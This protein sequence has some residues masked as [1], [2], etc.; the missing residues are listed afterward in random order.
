M[1][2]PVGL[3]RVGLALVAPAASA[4]RREAGVGDEAFGDVA[5]PGDEDGVGEG[6]DLDVGAQF[7][8]GQALDQGVAPLGRDIQHHAVL[9]APDEEVEQQTSR[10]RQKRAEAKLSGRQGLHV[11]R[12]QVVQ[13]GAGVRAG[14]ADQ[15]AAVEAGDGHTAKIGTGRG[16][17][18]GLFLPHARRR[19]WYF[20]PFKADRS[21][22]PSV[23]PLRVAP[24]PHGMGRNEGDQA[25]AYLAVTPSGWKSCWSSRS[26]E[27]IMRATKS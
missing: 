7:V 17:R 15:G 4:E 8:H 13:E 11:L 21:A 16:K 14:D 18:Q 22:A 19:P 27:A 5:A 10:R 2:L 9:L 1:R 26:S 25:T 24:P 6:H 3:G 23:T 20:E 12:Q